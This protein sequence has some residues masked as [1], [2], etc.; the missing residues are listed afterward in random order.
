MQCSDIGEGWFFTTDTPETFWSSQRDASQFLYKEASS[1]QAE[2]RKKPETAG[3]IIFLHQSLIFFFLGTADRAQ[4]VGFP[5]EKL[6]TAT[7]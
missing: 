2:G 7:S 5:P 3:D 1:F 4:E 6:A